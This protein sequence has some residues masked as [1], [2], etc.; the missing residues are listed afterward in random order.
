MPRLTDSTYLKQRAYLVGLWDRDGYE[1]TLIRPTE[2]WE[3][4]GFF[5]LAEP[6]TDEQALAHRR[7]VTAEDPSLANRAGKAYVRLLSEVSANDARLAAMPASLPPRKKGDP[8]PTRNITVR[9]LVRPEIDYKRL[10]H[11]LYEMALLDEKRK[12]SS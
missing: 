7:E 4:H 10:A 9:T 2:Q 1:L 11:A 6:L 12:R 5:R 8:R 3:L